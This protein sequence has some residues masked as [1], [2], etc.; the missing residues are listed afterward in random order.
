VSSLL[1]SRAE[2]LI[3]ID[4]FIIAMKRM[5]D[6]LAAVFE[7]IGAK[8]PASPRK[9]V[10]SVEIELSGELTDYSV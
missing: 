6:E 9:V 10:Q 5:F 2:L 4:I 1:Q 3:E 8:L 7:Q